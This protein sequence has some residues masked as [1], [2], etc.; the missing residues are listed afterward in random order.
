MWR[1]KGRG[2]LL[3][4]PLIAVL[5]TRALMAMLQIISPGMF[6]FSLAKNFLTQLIGFPNF[7]FWRVSGKG[8]FKENGWDADVLGSHYFPMVTGLLPLRVSPLGKSLDS[9]PEEGWCAAVTLCNGAPCL[10]YHLLMESRDGG[11]KSNRHQTGRNI[12]KIKTDGKVK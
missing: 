10:G 6:S 1:T 2:S 8:Q 7:K 12:L 9:E 3:D 11:E 4:L 5:P